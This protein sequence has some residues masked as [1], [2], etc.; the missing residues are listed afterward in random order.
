MLTQ[1]LQ[2]YLNDKVEEYNQPRFIEDDPIAVPHRF[3]KKQDI[4]IAAFFAAI[5]AWGNRRTIIRK[6]NEL[7]AMM[8]DDP[9]AFILH[10]SEKDL[11]NLLLFKHR[12]FNADDLLYFISFFHRHY[13]AHESLEVAFLRADHTEAFTMEN[14]LNHFKQ[15]F[16]AEEHLRRTRKH[17][18][19]PAQKSAC[20]R[21]N[22]FMRWM[23]RK[24]HCGVDFGLWSGISP[25]QL[26]MPLDLHV[27]R[28]ARRIGLLNR[29]QTDWTAA[30]ELTAVCRKMDAKDPVK[31]DYAL[32]AMG[33]VE[34]F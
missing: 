11:H 26:I 23:V 5:F 19:S 31:Y 8:D 24:D 10:H 2:A 22:M 30:E 9:Y 18:S 12:T 17:I 15:V 6:T 25:A 21:L 1:E 14:A 28:V 27:A 4:E 13:A 32:F 16:F 33:V 20:K 3:S 29:Q 7:M 34:K